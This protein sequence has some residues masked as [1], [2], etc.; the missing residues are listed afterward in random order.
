MKQKADH[1]PT[2]RQRRNLKFTEE[3]IELLTTIREMI[4]FEFER[5]E[6]KFPGNPQPE[7]PPPETKGWNPPEDKGWNPSEDKTEKKSPRP[8]LWQRIMSLFKRKGT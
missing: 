6:M 1:I 3:R 4:E 7:H 8:T 2:E 5:R